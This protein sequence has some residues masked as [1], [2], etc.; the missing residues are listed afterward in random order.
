MGDLQIICGLISAD[1]RSEAVPRTLPSWFHLLLHACCS[2]TSQKIEL[3]CKL[4]RPLSSL[5]ITHF[6]SGLVDFIGDDGTSLDR[7]P[8]E[9]GGLAVP[10]DALK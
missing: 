5:S 7:G 4:H 6:T 1:G 10:Q 3:V 2:S 8:H 9:S